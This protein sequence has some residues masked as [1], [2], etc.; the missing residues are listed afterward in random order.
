MASVIPVVVRCGACGNR[1]GVA[2]ASDPA[3]LP[4]LGV[5]EVFESVRGRTRRR[6]GPIVEVASHDQFLYA[7][8]YEKGLSAADS[9]DIGCPSRD[10]SAAFDL[11]TIRAKAHAA[12]RRGSSTVRIPRRPSTNG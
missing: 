10:C 8:T 7:M 2:R 3:S 1:L 9:G 6:S 11:A 12:R 5:T 4:T